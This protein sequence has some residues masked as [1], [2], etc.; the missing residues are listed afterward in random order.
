MEGESKRL[1]D[2]QAVAE[3]EANATRNAP[4]TAPADAQANLEK[5]PTLSTLSPRSL[6]LLS[7]V[8]KS[9]LHLH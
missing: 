3:R 9:A 2:K 6:P 4:G 5:V 7:V 8:R 1:A